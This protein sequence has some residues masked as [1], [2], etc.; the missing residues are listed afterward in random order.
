MHQVVDDL[1]RPL[2]G[3]LQVLLGRVQ[4]AELVEDAVLR[5]ARYR[6]DAACA[7]VARRWLPDILVLDR[8]PLDDIRNSTSIS[9]VMKN[10]DLFN[11]ETLDQVW[12][13]Q[14]PLEEY[15]FQRYTRSSNN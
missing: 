14:K 2:R 3:V 9:M 1:A 15:G 4:T 7:D 6:H 11:A 8:N 12:P 13:E 5:P 10:G